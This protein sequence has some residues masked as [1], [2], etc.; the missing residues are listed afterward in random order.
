[1]SKMKCPNPKCGYEWEA[2]TAKPKKCPLCQA[3]L[4][5]P[6]DDF[7]KHPDG[8]PKIAFEGKRPPKRKEESE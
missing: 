3:W 7:E 4:Y 8:T 1:M 5:D 2:R 6:R